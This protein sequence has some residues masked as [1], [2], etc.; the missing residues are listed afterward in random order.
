MRCQLEMDKVVYNKCQ[1]YLN[2]SADDFFGTNALRCYGQQNSILDGKQCLPRRPITDAPTTHP[3][4]FPIQTLSPTITLQ[5]MPLTDTNSNII[6]NNHSP[7]NAAN[8]Y[9]FKHYH[10]Q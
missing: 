9:K 3:T 6:T 7:N 8:R 2:F 5:T 10:Q 4:H 1:F